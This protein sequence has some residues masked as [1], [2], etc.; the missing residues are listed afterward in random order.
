MEFETV[1][2]PNMLLSFSGVEGNSFA[3]S[4]L[5]SLSSEEFVDAAKRLKNDG[6]D[7]AY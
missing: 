1:G 6:A 3:M 4:Q 5:G 7:R 2:K